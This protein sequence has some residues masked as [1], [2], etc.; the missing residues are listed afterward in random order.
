MELLPVGVE[1]IRCQH[2][3]V[4]SVTLGKKDRQRRSEM[5]NLTFDLLLYTAELCCFLLLF[6]THIDLS[7][8]HLKKEKLTEQTL[9]SFE[10]RDSQFILY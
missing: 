9:P 3:P 2:M 8:L 10:I 4:K 5:N 6:M 7:S 1:K